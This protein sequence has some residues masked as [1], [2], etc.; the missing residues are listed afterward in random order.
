M[1]LEI[2]GGIENLHGDGG[3]LRSCGDDRGSSSERGAA[4]D[5]AA[6]KLA[7]SSQNTDFSWV[8]TKSQ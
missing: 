2:Q 7:T 3:V 5:G 1:W 6:H 4:V 8:L